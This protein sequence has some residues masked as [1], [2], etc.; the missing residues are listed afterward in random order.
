MKPSGSFPCS[1][2]SILSFYPEPTVSNRSRWGHCIFR[3]T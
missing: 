2:Q 3:L 1:Q